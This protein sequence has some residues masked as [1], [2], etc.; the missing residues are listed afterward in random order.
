[1]GRFDLNNA[2]DFAK[3]T[4]SDAATLLSDFSG[5]NPGDWDIQEGSYNGVL[6]HVFK[7]KSDWDGALGNITDSGGRRLAIFKFPYVDGQTTDDLGRQGESFDLDIL[8]HGPRY[9]NGLLALMAELNK[10]TPGELVHPVRGKIKVKAQHYQLLHSSEKR[11]AVA[12]RLTL[13]EH[14][15]TLGGFGTKQDATVKGALAKALDAIQ[16]IENVITNVQGAIIF[17]SDVKAHF[18]ALLNDFKGGYSTVLGRIN[19]TYNRGGST[20]MPALLPVNN[21]GTLN[22]DG[23]VKQSSFPSVASPSDPF[24]SVPVAQVSQAASTAVATAQLVKEVNTLRGNLTTI[25]DELSASGQ[26]GEG[27]LV[28]YDDILNLKLAAI[29]MQDALEKGIASSQTHLVNYVTPRVMSLREVAFENGVDVDRV[30]DLEVLNPQL[31]STNFIDKGTAV[32]VPI[33]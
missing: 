26:N 1:M 24:Q 12:I 10:P 31:L 6:F 20:D 5:K 9:K 33:A 15:F 32:Q 4:L 3:V 27:S 28:F 16:K 17:A 18:V 8:I 19:V 25:V 11:K 13:V 22:S 7:S 23:S 21:G 2:A 14:S 29:A 30:Y